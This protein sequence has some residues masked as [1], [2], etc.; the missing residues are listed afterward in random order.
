MISMP[1]LANYLEGY[2][3]FLKTS[4]GT[5]W[6]KER[7]EKIKIF[8][9]VFSK[10]MLSQEQISDFEQ[11][12]RRVLKDLWAMAIWTNKDRRIEE[13]I[14][15]NGIDLLRREFYELL[16]GQDALHVRFDRFLEKVW[17]LGVS[18]ITEIMC[19][20][21]PKTYAM[22]NAKVVKALK[23][24]GILDQI[25]LSKTYIQNPNYIRGKQYEKI[26]HFLSSLKNNIK[27]FMGREI[28]FVELDYILY[29]IA[30]VAETVQETKYSEETEVKTPKITTHEEAQYYLLELG[31]LLGYATYVAKADRGKEVQG[32][33]LG[34]I[35]D[36]VEI[37][38]WLRSYPSSTSPETIDVLWFDSSGETLRYAFEVSHTS[39]LR[40]DLASLMGIID[41]VRKAF[42]VAPEERR[43]A[44]NKLLQGRPYS[45]HKTRLHFISYNDLAKL[46]DRTK[47]LKELLQNIG[48]E[49]E[50]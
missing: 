50:G 29:Y 47:S 9:K 12:L 33:S 11:G 45:R 19:F 17:G 36:L 42:I 18:A 41:V 28:D 8:Q 38:D 32:K 34:E 48:I 7:K 31:K 16:Y 3:Q 6:E 20:T 26:L 4:Q 30:E 35:A 21:Q 10:E 5:K 1:T 46:Y 43:E 13:I 25:G 22:W 2:K 14:E 49:I 37:P 27:D 39:D 15:K 44:F 24:M 40:K 23:K